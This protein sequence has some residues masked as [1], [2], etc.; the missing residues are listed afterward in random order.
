MLPPLIAFS[1]SPLSAEQRGGFLHTLG[2]G[3]A[4]RAVLLTG[5]A[6]GTVPGAN[7]KGKVMVTNGCGHLVLHL[8]QVGILVHLGNVDAHGARLAMP[9]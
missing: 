5:A 7:L 4:E 6:S 8:R 1:P 2:D 3:H 9:Q